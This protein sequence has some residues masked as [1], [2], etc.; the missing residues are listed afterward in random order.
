MRKS[1]VMAVV[2][3][4][5]IHAQVSSQASPT[6]KRLVVNGRPVTTKVLEI[7]GKHFVAI[8]DLAQTLG[9]TVGYGDEQITLTFLQPS[10]P[11][12][13]RLET[14]RIRGTLT[15]FFNFNYGNKPDTGS[16]VWLIE[17]HVDIPDNMMVIGIGDFL[18][19]GSAKPKIA[20][21][22]VADGI[23]NFELSDVPI[24]QYT[25]ILKSNHAKGLTTRD[26]QGNVR[27]RHVQIKAGEALDASTDFGANS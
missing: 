21:Y 3:L 25:L 5:S 27:V 24:G 22:T 13:S 18:V 16:Q 11:T 14:G 26:I 4:G 7:E 15:Y 23:G 20:K 10:L 8:E 19:V 12:S 2:T 17:G 9:G 6:F 1:I